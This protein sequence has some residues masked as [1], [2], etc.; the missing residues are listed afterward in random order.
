MTMRGEV[1]ISYLISRKTKPKYPCRSFTRTV[2]LSKSSL[3]FFF[4]AKYRIYIFIFMHSL[5]M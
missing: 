2:N 5:L 4:F 1:Q 3:F